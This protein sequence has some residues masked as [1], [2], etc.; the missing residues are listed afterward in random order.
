ML[1]KKREKKSI[2]IFKKLRMS[3]PEIAE[4]EWRQGE[5]INILIFALWGFGVLASMGH[6]YLSQETLV[7]AVALTSKVKEER[8]HL[9]KNY[10]S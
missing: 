1:E 3:T 9:K 4:W 2:W 7:K 6:V 8:F 10:N 5:R